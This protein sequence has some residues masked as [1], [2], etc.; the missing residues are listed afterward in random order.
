METSTDIRARYPKELQTVDGRKF[1]IRLM[2]PGE[3]DRSAVLKF[4]K[5]LSED[6]LLYL[7]TDITDPAVVAQWADSLRSGHTTT[8]LAEVTRGPLANSA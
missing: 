4:A 1:T 7:R 8:I 5:D 3:G 2:E 6:D